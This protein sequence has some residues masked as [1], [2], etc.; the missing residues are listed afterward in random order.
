MS[1]KLADEELRLH[2]QREQQE[3]AKQVNWV[4]S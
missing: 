2:E 4:P 1:K 3:H